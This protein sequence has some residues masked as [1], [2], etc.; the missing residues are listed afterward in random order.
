MIKQEGCLLWLR[1]K[2]SQLKINYHVYKKYQ[3]LFEIMGE[4]S[5]FSRSYLRILSS[6]FWIVYITTKEKGKT[7][8][9]LVICPELHSTLLTK[10][11]HNYLAILT[12]DEIK[13]ILARKIKERTHVASKR[14]YEEYI[15]KTIQECYH[16]KYPDQKS[17]REVIV[18]EED[19]RK[20]FE[21]LIPEISEMYYNVKEECS[22]D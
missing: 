21:S 8:E 10:I 15:E 6:F 17:F 14:S 22:V 3:D 20:I 5:S 13:K 9:N 12:E 16:R 18:N 7:L 2:L 19:G 11:F 1:A 4:K